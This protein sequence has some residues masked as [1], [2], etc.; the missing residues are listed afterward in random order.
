MEKMGNN[1]MKREGNIVSISKIGKIPIFSHNLPKFGVGD[2]KKCEKM[3]KR[4]YMEREGKKHS[5]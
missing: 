5:F 1:V 4:K 2:E 3:S